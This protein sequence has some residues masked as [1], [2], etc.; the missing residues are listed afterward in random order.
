FKGFFI[1]HTWI[2]VHYKR[3]KI[4][5]QAP[6][7]QIFM[8]CI[9]LMFKCF[10][11]CIGKFPSIWVDCFYRF[12]ICFFFCF[13]WSRS[14]LYL[15]NGI[16]IL[17]SIYRSTSRFVT[18]RF[19]LLQCTCFRKVILLTFL[20]IALYIRQSLISFFCFTCSPS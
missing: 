11:Y 3:K 17:S 2:I 15:S 18:F 5:R 19:L 13:S 10:F 8:R 7:K 6:K 9:P 20:R 14:F 16:L 4:F 12:S 1:K